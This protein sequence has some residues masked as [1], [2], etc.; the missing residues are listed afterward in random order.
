MTG[1]NRIPKNAKLL[2]YK[3]L[4]EFWKRHQSALKRIVAKEEIDLEAFAKGKIPELY[5]DKETLDKKDV[6][7][8][9]EALLDS[10]RKLLNNKDEKK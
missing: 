6:A 10:L 2:T 3:D 8:R 5:L 9:F 7:D 4:D 1:K